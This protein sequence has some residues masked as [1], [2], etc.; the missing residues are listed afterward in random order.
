MDREQFWGLTGVAALTAAVVVSPA[1]AQ[2]QKRNSSDKPNIIYILADDLGYGD[3][4]CYV[5]QRFETPNLDRMARNGML[6]T[7]N[8]AGNALSAPSRCC[9][10]TGKHSGHTRIRANFSHDGSRVALLPEDV[11]IPELLKSAG[12][13]TG[14][15]GKWG[16]GEL[17]TEGTPTRKGFDEFF[18][19]INQK[20]AHFYYFPYLQHNEEQYDIPE[21]QNGRRG[22]YTHDLIHAR[23]KEYITRQAESGKPFF[24]YLAYTLP[25]SELDVPEDDLSKFRGK[26]PETPFP[27]SESKGYRPQPEPKA[28]FMGMITRLDRHVG[29]ILDLVR[30]LGIEKN[31]IVIFTSD[32]GPHEEGGA[33]PVFFNSNGG[34]RGIKRDLFDGGIREPMIVQWKGVVKKGSRTDHMTAFWDVMPTFCELAGVEVP[35]ACDGESFL[36]VLKGVDEPSADR[37]FYWELGELGPFRRALRMGDFKAV[38]YGLSKP[39][40]IYDI[41]HDRAETRDLAAERPDLVARAQEL[42]EEMHVESPAFPMKDSVKK[43]KKKP[44]VVFDRDDE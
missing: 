14:M 16:L 10:M 33:D 34:L 19:Y 9:L 12:Y 6:F 28:A 42:F 4:S 3:L 24:A 20:H 43:K 26:Y 15:F 5:Q 39:V 30:E 41:V 23:A 17:E 27:G 1:H 8:Y 44:T 38:Q 21:N 35:D 37:V 36:G 7:Q 13:A 40:Q 29:E 2:K 18:G 31:T 32:N 11:T 22:V 25:H